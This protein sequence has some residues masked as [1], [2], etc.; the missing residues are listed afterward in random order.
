MKKL[1][2]LYNRQGISVLNKT[3][4]ELDIAEQRESIR[5][6]TE[7]IMK[8]K[9]KGTGSSFDTDYG[10]ES[11]LFLRA[12]N[13]SP[14]D[15][16]NGKTEEIFDK[17]KYGKRITDDLNDIYALA[18]S[19]NDELDED[20]VVSKVEH[21][22]NVGSINYVRKPLDKMIKYLIEELKPAK[23]C[24]A[25]DHIKRPAS[26]NLEVAKAG[27]LD[28]IDRVKI[29]TLYKTDGLD[30]PMAIKIAWSGNSRAF[31][32]MTM[33]RPPLRLPRDTLRVGATADNNLK[34]LAI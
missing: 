24:E 14:F 34:A 18:K 4:A 9:K 31:K 13:Y 2:G 7:K 32:L 10:A 8:L 20:Y 11:I 26:G 30:V 23:K 5:Y 3:L 27:V 21:G 25:C 6:V 15:I 33:V 29:D 19:V 16:L 22:K 1:Y 17:I 28:F 12:V